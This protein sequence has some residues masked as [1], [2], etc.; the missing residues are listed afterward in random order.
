MMKKLRKLKIKRTIQ[1][2]LISVAS[3]L[4]IFPLLVTG[5]LSYQI[6]KTELNKKGEIA[7]KNSVKQAIQIIDAKQKEVTL[8]HV[9]LADAQEQVKVYLLGEKSSEGKRPI[10]KNIDLGK[11][12]YFVA[13]DEK[14]LEV[15]H[16]SLEGQNVW[17]VEDKSGTGYKFVQEQIRIGMNGGGFLKYNWTLPGSEQIAQKI[18][19]QEQDPHW[20]WIISAGSYMQ[21]FNEGS[22][23]ILRLLLV[24]L[25]I[26][27][28]VGFTTIIIFARHISMP[29]KK[30]SN[31]LEEV[32]RGNLQI[33]EIKI[34]N[35]DETGNLANSFNTMLKNM[36]GLISTIKNS[37]TT[38]MQYS[39]SLANITQE[40]S[41]A[42]NE[43]AT[44]IQEVAQ[45]VSEE[46]TSTEQAVSKVDLLAR[47]IETVTNATVNMNNLSTDTNELSD[48]GLKAVETLIN[49]TEKNNNATDRISEVIIKVNES[50]NKIH[51]ITETITQIAQ[52][53]NLLAL[54]ASI[55]AAR[56]GEAGRGF[57]VVADEI[58]KLAEQSETAVKE[59]KGIIGEIHQYSDSSV[60][61]MDIVR[62]VSKDQNTAVADTMS[63]FK[64]I[65]NSI[66]ILI[67]NVNEISRESMAMRSMKDEIV[68]NMEN[69]SAS[70][71]QTSAATE[72]VSAS[73]EE[74]LA[75]I[76]EVSSHAQELK[77]LSLILE[78]AIEE[79]KI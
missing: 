72:E 62:V 46:A 39:N 48:K 9:S 55:E 78:K 41:R 77:N 7:L 75:T 69:I 40:T 14:G 6:A 19:Y 59:I 63:A 17:E 43:V 66:K 5:I 38:V 23:K 15:A 71:Q 79:F 42:I 34:K 2:K 11:N 64:E 36:R 60:E 76:E 65:S 21:D 30:I 44:T 35:T 45:A 12:G 10:N 33:D 57:A 74:Q 22:N 28:V 58:R 54:N 70:T 3:V 73:S 16:P 1:T 47:N 27:L 24:I 49:T 18:S 56:A 32:S 25:V 8:G 20:G 67:Q 50:S 26:S 61:T 4:L 13:Y 37:S 52:Q 29:I 51:V 53:T 68:A 31:S